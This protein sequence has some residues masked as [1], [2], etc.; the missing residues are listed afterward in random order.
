M[1][2]WG[3]VSK[4]AANA[5]RAL[6]PC[7]VCGAP[8]A[9]VC[10]ECHLIGCHKHSYTN[11]SAL[12]SVCSKCLSSKY[13]WAKEDLY[14][15]LPND[16]PYNEPPWVILGVNRD[17]TEDEIRESQRR[18]SREVHPDK[19]NGDDSRQRAVNRAAEEMLRRAT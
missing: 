14:T 5:S 12:R 3:T 7:H 6:P 18:L 19:N 13:P 16:W 2:F 1:G 4:F 9:Q 15:D 8:G 10:S 11:V 17:A